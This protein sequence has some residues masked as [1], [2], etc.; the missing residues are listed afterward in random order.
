MQMTYHVEKCLRASSL[1]L[2]TFHAFLSIKYIMIPLNH[3]GWNP[4][5]Q[6]PPSSAYMF[7]MLTIIV[8]LASPEGSEGS[9]TGNGII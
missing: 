6:I 3:N 9:K 2:S 1:R 8:P 5:L 4:I 7:I